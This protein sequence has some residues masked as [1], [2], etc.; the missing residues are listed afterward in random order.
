[1]VS[2][3]DWRSDNNSTLTPD[4]TRHYYPTGVAS[5][6]RLERLLKSQYLTPASFFFHL[7]GPYLCFDIYGPVCPPQAVAIVFEAA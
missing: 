5:L 6:S 1:M 4:R 3:Y 2:V 7:D